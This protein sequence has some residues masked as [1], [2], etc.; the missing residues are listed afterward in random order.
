MQLITTLHFVVQYHEMGKESCIMARPKNPAPSYLLHKK[1]GQARVRLKIAGRHRDVYLGD[2]GSP[3]SVEK[4]HRV[5][6][7][8]FG[9]NGYDQPGPVPASQATADDWTVAE[10]AVKYDDFARSHY[11]KNGEP[12]DDRYRAVLAPLVTVYGSTLAKE[13]GPKKLKALREW[14]VQRGN[15]RSAEFD[16]QGNLVK[17]GKP[18]GREY[19]NN[20]MKAVVRMFKWAVTEEKVPPSVPDALTKVGGLRKGRDD[21]F[22]SRSRSSRYLK[23]IFSRW[24][25]RRLRRLLPCFR[26]RDWRGRGRTKSP[27]CGRATSTATGTCGYTGQTVTSWSGS[28]MKRWCCL[29]PEPKSF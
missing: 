24:S 9:D 17:P 20:L 28:T 13:F 19:V 3:E 25:R 14:I 23:S 8:H 11:V 15:V 16:K 2:Y 22:G 10:M 18:L 29:G 21:G 5:L 26:Y 1:S 12:T 27:S 6:A 4:Y 7:E